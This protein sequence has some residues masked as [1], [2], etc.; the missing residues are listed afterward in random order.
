MKICLESHEK[1]YQ[2]GRLSHCFRCR[3]DNS[4]GGRI[5]TTS[6]FNSYYIKLKEENGLKLKE[7]SFHHGFFAPQTQKAHQ[8]LWMSKQGKDIDLAIEGEVFN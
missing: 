2:Q 5:T 6:W 4:L 7:T 1:L 8:S 3:K